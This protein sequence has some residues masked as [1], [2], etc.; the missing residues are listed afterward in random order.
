VTPSQ[1]II[2]WGC[3][4]AG[5]AGSWLCSGMETGLYSVNR[6]K[7]AVRVGQGRPSAR[8]LDREIRAPERALAA[9]LISNATFNY[10]AAYGASGLLAGWGYPGWGIVL[11]NAAVLT[12]ILFV[13][14]E[15]LPKEIFRQEADRITY[16]LSWA[17]RA[18]RLILTWTGALPLVSAVSR[19]SARALGAP[20]EEGL[21]TSA[22]ERVAAML[23]ETASLG[24]LSERQ[25]GLVDRALAFSRTTVTDE[26]TPWSRITPAHL[27]WDRGRLLRHMLS[28]NRPGTPVLD[29]QGRVEGIIQQLDLVLNPDAPV[30]ELMR[31]P[32]RL[33]AKLPLRE[34]MLQMSQE[35]AA[36]AIVEHEGRPVGVVA[37]RDLVEP[38]TGELAPW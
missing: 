6:V 1:Q 37:L 33:A 32:L 5:L 13:C 9:L 14:S 8:V 23:K 18:M 31:R 29:R 22:R 11:I 3:T 35:G 21:A 17:L 19:A 30:R 25:A 12:P 36:M 16:A 20:V 4:L 15:A 2:H 38:L 24:V 34:A 26:M 27:D 10:A 28:E 7:L